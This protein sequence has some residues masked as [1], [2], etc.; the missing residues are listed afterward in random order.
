[1]ISFNVLAQDIDG[2]YEGQKA[3]RGIA[4]NCGEFEKVNR[5]AADR[6][7][8]GTLLEVMPLDAVRR[9]SAPTKHDC[10]RGCRH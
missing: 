9:L 2:P 4:G 3:S 7:D 10:S 8:P 6:Q 1:V 5:P